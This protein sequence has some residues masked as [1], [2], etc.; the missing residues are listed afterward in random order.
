M[1][2]ALRALRSV[3][4]GSA[5]L[6]KS[7]AGT[8]ERPP[9]SLGPAVFDCGFGLL[10]AVDP[11]RGAAQLTFFSAFGRFC[12]TEGNGVPCSSLD[13]LLTGDALN[14]TQSSDGSGPFV[15]FGSA[16]LPCS[17]DFSDSVGFGSCGAF[18]AL[19]AAGFEA[20][21]FFVRCGTV[22]LT[23]FILFCVTFAF[24]AGGF[25][26]PSSCSGACG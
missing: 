19:F 8:S 2:F 26:W 18:F 20:A 17:S 10:W 11:L 3:P 24:P 4:A 21:A 22:E 25:T 1:Y 15:M 13:T 16:G 7:P 6:F 5:P 12:G 23:F 14:M 9:A